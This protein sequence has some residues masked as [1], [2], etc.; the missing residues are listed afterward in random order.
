MTILAP[1]SAQELSTMLPEALS[2]TTGPSAIR[3][4]KGVARQVPPEQVGSGLA[5]RRARIGGDV[6]I[7]AVGKMLEAAEDAALLLDEQGVNATVW[8]VRVVRPLDPAMLADAAAHRLVVTVEDG[9]RV[10][11]AGSSIADAIAA[12]DVG[13][14]SPPMLVLGVPEAYIPQGKPA[15]I[16]SDLGLDGPGVAAA[17]SNALGVRGLRLSR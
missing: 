14:A 4:P 12:L 9:I 7:L 13:R 8:D 11:G 15:Q 17:V 1:S 2:I 10:G 6:C 5:A 16:L 3:Y